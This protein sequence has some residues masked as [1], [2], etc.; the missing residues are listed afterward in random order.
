MSCGQIAFKQLGID[1]D[2]YISYEIDKYAIQ[3]TQHNFPNTEQHGDVF[4]ADFTE[5]RGADWLIGGSPC[6]KWSI[7][8]KNDRETQPNSGIGWELFSQYV[9]A[10]HEAE[11][12]Y[13]LYEN[14][15]SMSKEIRAAIDK[16]FGFEAVEINSALV[17]AQNRQRLYWVGRRNPNGSYSRVQ[18]SLPVDR[19]I[20]L[21]DLL[22]SGITWNE[23]SYALTTRCMGAI[24]S[25]T[26]KKNRHTMMAESLNE[27]GRIGTIENDLK[28]PEHDGKQYRVYSP[29]GK[30][31]TLCGQ[32]GGVGAKTGLYAVSAS[33]RL[34]ATPV[35]EVKG[36]LVNINGTQYPIKLP[37]GKYAIRKLTINE[38]KR[39]QTVPDWYDMSVISN[40]QAYKCLGNGWTVAVIMHLISNSGAFPEEEDKYGRGQAY[41]I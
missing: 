13:F 40:S 8:Q 23:K 7:A 33:G 38:C 24:P 19:G 17:S 29:N 22:D 10:I 9:R 34:Y 11:P 31:T 2:R 27:P 36:G 12:E 37:D 25:D 21:R 3:V 39:L 41:N 4:A 6:T 1:V 32:G 16:A 28:S 30:S 18:I 26:L 15:K 14:N 5:Y 35:Y 20:V